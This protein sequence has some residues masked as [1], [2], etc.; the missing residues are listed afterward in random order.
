MRRKL[1][2]Y[3]STCIHVCI[4]KSYNIFGNVAFITH[5]RRTILNYIHSMK[6]KVYNPSSLS[7]VKSVRKVVPTTA[8]N[9]DARRIALSHE[10][11]NEH[12]HWRIICGPKK[13]SD[14]LIPWLKQL[15]EIDI[16][17]LN[18][19]FCGLAVSS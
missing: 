9:F 5:I 1:F 15:Q 7:S 10:S 18:H 4:L 8:W 14:S 17:K 19:C 12:G 16:D 11:A 13:T 6:I 3:G 2:N